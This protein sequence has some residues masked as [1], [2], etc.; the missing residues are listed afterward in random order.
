MC[1]L[2]KFMRKFYTQMQGNALFSGKIYT[3]GKKFTQPP[4]PDFKS[5]FTG[6]GCCTILLLKWIVVAKLH[7]EIHNFQTSGAVTVTVTVIAMVREVTDDQLSFATQRKLPS[8]PQSRRNTSIGGQECYWN[9]NYQ[10]QSPEELGCWNLFLFWSFFGEFWELP[11]GLALQVI[12]KVE[13]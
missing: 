8:W 2:S 13:E 12:S 11:I 7:S 10:D 4:K 3:A 5:V 6:N 1:K 9:L